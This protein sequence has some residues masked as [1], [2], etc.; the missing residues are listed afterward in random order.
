[1]AEKYKT[2]PEFKLEIGATPITVENYDVSNHMCDM[3]VTNQCS[4]LGIDVNNKGGKYKTSVSNYDEIKYYARYSGD[5]WTQIFGGHIDKIAY[6]K[7]MQGDTIHFDCRSYEQKFFFKTLNVTYIN[8]CA[9]DII[10]DIISEVNENIAVHFTANNVGDAYEQTS[11][12]DDTCKIYQTTGST[13]T[14]GQTFKYN[15]ENV[16]TVAVRAIR[17]GST[18]DGKDLV[19]NLYEWDTD[20]ATTVAGSVIAQDSYKYTEITEGTSTGPDTLIYFVLD[21]TG[22]DTSNTYLLEFC[23][24]NDADSSNY[25]LLGKYT[26]SD[27]L[28]N[29]SLYEEKSIQSGEDLYIK[30]NS[31]IYEVKD[32]DGFTAMRE[33][34]HRLGYDWYSD[35]DKDIHL[36]PRN[37][38]AT[39]TIITGEDILQL[40][41][42]RDITSLANSI[43]IH[44]GEYQI[45]YPEESDSL[46]E[47]ED[48][49][50]VDNNWKFT[51]YGDG[52][53]DGAGEIK[54]IDEGDIAVGEKFVELQCDVVDYPPEPGLYHHQDNCIRYPKT[55]DD[56][57]DDK[58]HTLYFIARAAD[59]TGINPIKIRVNVKID[60]INDNSDTFYQDILLEDTEWKEF[61]LKL[62]TIN[63]VFDWRGVNY[64]GR[65]WKQIRSVS[66][67]VRTK[68]AG[69]TGTGTESAHV[70]GDYTG[71][72][73]TIGQRFV[74]D[75]TNIDKIMFKVKKVNSP[76]DNIVVEIY[77]WDTDYATTIAGTR[78]Q[79]GL[80]YDDYI[81]TTYK[82]QRASM[83]FGTTYPLKEG[84]QYLLHIGVTVGG[85]ADASNYF[86]FDTGT[87]T[88]DNG[89]Y[90]I[91]DTEQSGKSLHF[92][93]QYNSRHATSIGI[94]GLTFVGVDH[95]TASLNDATS[96]GNY[97]TREY[98]TREEEI[99]TSYEA[100]QKAKQTLRMLGKGSE[101]WTGTPGDTKDVQNTAVVSIPGTT[102]FK[103]GDSVKVQYSEGN[104]DSDFRIESISY[105]FS[106]MTGWVTTLRLAML[107]PQMTVQELLQHVIL[108]LNSAKITKTKEQ[109]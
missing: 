3:N 29:G 59:V 100:M 22:L 18:L 68:D 44:G 16:I 19:C 76:N 2:K 49:T 39:E 35:F 45:V 72:S 1:M 95:I 60:D 47:P 81:G 92:D 17:V 99:K 14:V 93:I 87:G 83:D 103:P 74:A 9:E 98:I 63:N 105:S 79:A 28:A 30:F 88:N 54:M 36:I 8:M 108:N 12:D 61:A 106:K 48:Q 51:D 65:R 37:V 7:N 53:G 90:Y 41:Y 70:Y 23:T 4:I 27:E 107:V 31:F 55:E 67:C 96:Q 25:Y 15:K 20:Y 77:E 57:V 75:D 6:R 34:C 71:S 26:A 33:V 11:S 109:K 56:I 42:E 85:S 10:K 102:S 43:Q 89:N 62:P 66:W 78:K 69:S 40:S 38:A 46:T 80:L 73:N 104:L 91:G 84:G 97:D 21:A 50:W 5:T 58:Y 101:S 32:K 52:D 13:H 82:Y 64:I 94:D 86:V 24:S